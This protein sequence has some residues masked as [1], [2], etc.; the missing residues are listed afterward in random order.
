M[1]DSMGKLFGNKCDFSVQFSSQ[2]N[3]APRTDVEIQTKRG[4]DT[5]QWEGGRE[6]GRKSKWEIH[7]RGKGEGG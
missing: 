6:G 5:V 2:L 3:P 7:F 4:T 1:N